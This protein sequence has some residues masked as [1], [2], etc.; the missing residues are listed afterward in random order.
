MIERFFVSLF[1]S[2]VVALTSSM[3]SSQIDLMNQIR[4]VRNEM[5]SSK[6]IVSI[7]HSIN[8]TDKFLLTTLCGLFFFCGG[9]KK[10]LFF[11]KKGKKQKKRR[12]LIRF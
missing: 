3:V 2:R 5:E 12:I 10:E 7:R 8:T 4:D 9:P 6:T 1:S 11:Q